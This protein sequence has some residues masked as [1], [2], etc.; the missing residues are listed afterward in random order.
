[1]TT[2]ARP[3]E[4]G[5]FC[6]IEAAMGAA[7]ERWRFDMARNIPDHVLEAQKKIWQASFGVAGEQ[8][9]YQQTFAMAFNANDEQLEE[10]VTRPEQHLTKSGASELIGK[11]KWHKEKKA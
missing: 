5:H 11:N 10:I 7:S 2:G 9:T 6:F 4:G 1:V 3:G 8:A